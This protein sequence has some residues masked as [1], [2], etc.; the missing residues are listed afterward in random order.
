[1]AEV[2]AVY[3]IEPVPRTAADILPANDAEHANARPAPTS[4]NKWLT[5][6][7]THDAATV[8]AKMFEEASRRDGEHQRPWVALVDGNQHQIDRIDAEAKARE[9]NITVL[10]DFVHVIEYLWKAAWSLHKEGDPAAELWVRH[11]AQNILAGK[12]TRVA[13]AIRRQATNAGLEPYTGSALIHAP[14]TSP[15]SRTTSTTRPR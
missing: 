10:V 7:V 1:M 14:P 4:K 11:H 6:S 12:A 5:A 3:E 2:A 8:V 15:T 13:G 9:V